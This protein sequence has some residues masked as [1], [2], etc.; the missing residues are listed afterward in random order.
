MNR[1]FKRLLSA[2]LSVA[3]L[4][5][6]LPTAVFADEAAPRVVYGSYD[7]DGE[8]VL[9]PDGTGVITTDEGFTLSK[10]AVPDE[11]D[12]NK[13]TITL[14]VQTSTTTTTV[15]PTAA[16]TVLVIDVSGSMDY[17]AECGGDGRHD[18]DCLHYTGRW[19]Q[20]TDDQTRMTAAKNAAL[21]FIESYAGETAGVGRYLAIVKFSTNA[22]TVLDWVD[23][24]GGTGEDGY[25]EA[26]SAINALSA[27]GGTNLDDGLETANELMED[28]AVSSVPAA[29]CNVIA[30]TD[31]IP[32]Y[33]NDPEESGWGADGI[34]GSGSS[35]SATI[36]NATAETAEALRENASV[37]TVC[38]GVANDECYNGGPTVGDFLEDSIATPEGKDEEGNAVVY[39][40]NADN[41]SE[42][43]AAFKA[44]TS[45]ITEGI[46]GEGFKVTD[47]MSPDVNLDQDSVNTNVYIHTNGTDTLEWNLSNPEVTEDGNTTYYTYTMSYEIEVD[48]TVEGFVE[49]KYYPANG[50]T[51]L[52]VPSADGEE[53]TRLYFPVPAVTGVAPRFTVIYE[54][55]E[56]GTIEGQD[57]NGQVVHEDIIMHAVTPEAPEVTPDE[58]YYFTGWLPVVAETVT[59]NVTYV[60]QYGSQFE[61]KIQANSAEE[62]YDGKEHTASGY[63]VTGMPEG[64]DLTGVTAEVSG[65]DAGTYLNQVVMFYISTADGTLTI[66]KRPVTLTSATV[67]KEYDGTPLTDDTITVGGSGWA[68]GEG[69]EY[70]VTGTQ[71]YVGQSSNE[72]TYELIKGTN[73]DNYD[74]TKTVGQLNVTDR[75]T[76]YEVTVTANSATYQYDGSE[77]SVDGFVSLTVTA[78]NGLTYTI[79]GL[80]AYGAGT[81]AGTYTVNIDGTAVVKDAAGE[82]VTAQ[83]NVNAI[84]GTLTITK[85]NVT[86]TSAS[87]EKE[88][89]GEPLTNDKVTVSG[90]G[91]VN[92][93]GASY[94]VTGSRTLVGTSENSF[95]YTL[96]EGTLAENYNITSVLGQL[97][98]TD[99]N[100]KYEITVK[101]N[102]AE[103]TYDGTEKTVKGFEKL[104]FTVDGNEYTVKGLTASASGTDAGTTT[105][106]V[107]GTP[108]VLDE[109]G[110]DVTKQFTVHVETGSLVINKKNVTITSPNATKMYDGT[111]LTNDEVTSEGFVEGEGAEYVVTGTQTLPGHSD[112][113]FTYSLIEGTKADNY[114]IE[115]VFGTLTVTER[116]EDAF[117]IQVIANSGEFKYDGEA[118]T[119]EG[120]T[121]PLVYVFDGVEFTVEGLSASV[122]ATDAGTY[123]VKVTGEAVVYDAARNDVT[124][125]FSVKTADGTMEITKRLV[126]LTSATDTKQYDGTPLTN[127]EVTVNG[128]G[129]AV[130]EGAT[131]DVTGSQLIVGSSANAF[132]YT[133]DQNTNADNYVITKTE[134]TLTVTNRDAKYQ[135]TVEANSDK[136]MYDGKEHGISGFKTLIFT[137]EGKSYTVEGLTAAVNGTDVN[138]YTANVTGTAVV[139]DAYGN[140]VTSEFAVTTQAGQLEIT[141]RE[142]ILTSATAEKEYDGTALTNGE[143]TVSGDLWADGEGASY[144]VTG[145]QTLVGSSENT[146]TYTL[147]ENTIADNYTI[148]TNNGTLTVKNR[149]AKYEITVEANSGS[150]MYDGKAMTVEGFKTLDFVVNG[151]KYTVSGLTAATTETDAGEY[152]VNVVGTAVVKDVNGNDVSAQFAVSTVNGSLVITKRQVTLTSASASKQYDGIALTNNT[153]TVSGDGFVEGEGATYNVTG[154]QTLVGDSK[155]AFTYTLNEGTKAEN[156]D[157]TKVEGTLKVLN[158]EK[159]FEI[160]VVANSGSKMYDGEA[161]T[162][163][164]FET[165]DYEIGGVKFTVEG[166]RASV[167]ATDAG[168]YT[169]E[170]VG[171]PIVK[172][173]DG[174]DVT[175]QFIVK[176]EN[177]KLVITKRQVTMTSATD[178]KQYDGTPLTSKEV[179]ETGDGFVAG[180]GATYDITGS[181]RV[182]GSSAN[183][184]TYTLDKNTI[185]DNYN[186]DVIYGQLTVTNRDAKFEIDVTANSGEFKYDGTEK[187]V[188]GIIEDTFVFNGE[189]FVVTGLTAKQTEVD[190]GTYAV[191]VE[192]TAVVTDAYDNVVTDQFAVET[193]AGQLVITKREVILTSATDEKEYDG[194]A[195]TNG[196]V[197]VTGDDWAKGEG[198]SYDVT[199][200]QTLVGSSENTF[201]YT[202]NENTDADNYTITTN[203]GILTVVTREAK[204][205]V[206]VEANSGEFL[207]DGEEKIVTD[208][209]TLEVEAEN[210]LIYKVEGLTA[211]GKGTDAGEYPVNITGTPV[212]KD[213]AGNDVTSEFAVRVIPGKLVINKR[214]VILTS[215]SASKQ[216]DGTALTDDTVTV[217][218]DGF[219]DGES[220][221]CVVTGTQTLVGFSSNYFTYTLGAGTKAENYDITKVEGTLTVTHRDAK[222]EITVEANSGEFKY[223]G[224]EKTVEGFKTLEFTVNGL[225]YTVEGLTAEAS[226]T[227]A[228]TYP[229]AITGSAIVL[230]ADGNDVTAEFIVHVID[231]TLVIAKRLVI[232]TSGSDSK[233]A[234]GTPLT[235]HEI[236]VTGDGWA[237]DEGADYDVTGVRRT[238]GVSENTFTYEL[239][240]NTKESNYE[241]VVVFGTLEVKDTIVIP[242]PPMEGDV[243]LQKVD[244]ADTDTVLPGAQF[245]LYRTNVVSNEH[246]DELVGIFT[247]DKHGIISVED[248]RPGK[249]YW[250]ETRAPEGYMLDD[251]EYHVAVSVGKLTAITVENVKTAIPEVF[252]LDHYAYVIG[253]PDGGVHP[254][255]TI[256][257][258]EVATIFFRLLSDEVRADF[259]TDE[260]DFTDVNSGDWFNRAVS[261]MAAMGV[262]K[263]YPDGSFHPNGKITRAE[264]AAI[265]ARFDDNG[266]TTTADF[267]DIYGHWGMDEIS[268]AANNGWILGYTDNTFKP[269]QFITR[270][271]A[272]TLVNRVLQRIVEDVD[273]LHEDMVIWPDNMDTSKWYY[274][275]VQEAT[276]SHYYFR[277]ANGFECWIDIRSVRDW[278]ELEG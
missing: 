237:E 84:P 182:V 12:P 78:K 189:T 143:V 161:M 95:T 36:N 254:E 171:T 110:H 75:G 198:A 168:T 67:S 99:R 187:T 147:N 152:P 69:A 234:D 125:Q 55:G 137:V 107:N 35:G 79:S 159:A 59:E 240:E 200:S 215:A 123:T 68:E 2:V 236:T 153:V 210:G 16:A 195:L 134:G 149:N 261:T 17:C 38:F 264:F 53:I 114:V 276:N 214:E 208:F 90:D 229:V 52:E 191:N 249:Y 101:S 221:D 60:A 8:W 178:T 235:N 247:T 3:M 30:L 21:G 105:V 33:Y 106:S 233:Y 73:A 157:I 24:S 102:S 4:I 212:V 46:S 271:E 196:E 175:D 58:K 141:K 119:V 238:T 167:T 262:V 103:Y 120:F 252:T 181:Q 18:S 64:Y 85:R 194:T 81:N 44:I 255:A 132:K 260:N 65:V 50:E 151:Q 188:E 219:A 111:P 225:K 87:A 86:F 27:N 172:D 96:N 228:G 202:L 184:F 258:A 160:T 163:E 71:T 197:T 23:V 277:K 183:L 231:G 130:G 51:Y 253:Y 224:E 170:V 26:V 248:L 108:M 173:A 80:K 232:L 82:D 174:N 19:A 155:N 126:T 109:D 207:Y 211:E 66:N 7:E 61:I 104:T 267:S 169:N 5:S 76:K 136:V 31:G 145:S 121:K 57:E 56:H 25:D 128:D 180:E 122:T 251:E 131:Y 273:D 154:S 49:G 124:D 266:D 268:I 162:V 13:Y 77:K 158:R 112:N 98:V 239:W 32:T 43:N 230:D 217:T 269:D 201:T 216:Y 118:K 92:G 204:Y 37:Y 139:R 199:G 205:E 190:A 14:E 28:D 100:T 41:S 177:G 203:N 10:V 140:D 135:I 117:E 192:G 150:K 193:H 176:T 142:V 263:G 39:A 144:D 97:T 220:A 11:D 275:A 29:N 227:D 241:I 70:V 274:L 113:A 257:R 270:A 209:I 94:N 15:N 1:S 93:E 116:G 245:A 20:V 242:M 34:G 74:I 88:Y 133:L 226:E 129:F 165:L 115:T 256:T 243:L 138:T 22:S 259:M 47:P 186:I 83:F 179:T 244:S 54:C 72:F 146:F 9:D 218:G 185:A 63:T 91:F 6:M 278:T 250:V 213:A 48:S 223:D 40:Y 62:T 127:E 222:F 164:G 265:A 89:D 166:I 206:E 156:Y 42:L 45:S 148:K 272:M 246:D